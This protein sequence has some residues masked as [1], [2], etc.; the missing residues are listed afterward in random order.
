[1]GI[2][3][4]KNETLVD[5]FFDDLKVVH[6]KSPVIQTNDYYPFGLTFNSYQRENSLPQHYLYQGMEL[7]P[8]TETYLTEYR[9][10][11]PALGRWN[12]IDPKAN[13]FHSPYVG[14]GNNPLFYIDPLGDTIIVNNTGYITRNDESDNLV[15]TTN[16]DG[17]LVALGEI[18][19][20][21]N[22]DD[23]YS[24]LLE[25]NI[26][27]SEGILNPLAFKALVTDGGDWDLKADKNSIFGL[28]ND[29]ETMF[30]FNGEKMESQDIGNHHFGAVALA[31]PIISTLLGEEGILKQAGLNQIEQARNVKARMAEIQRSHPIF[32]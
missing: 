3:C 27:E 12:Q 31:N 19:G 4:N 15:F 5:V 8:E 32:I 21:I 29:G 11:D 2:L 10:Y 9:T 30:T 17:E 18:G 13:E 6:T 14:M 24:N 1:M 25:Q 7:Q 20:E 26:E 22:V 28:G 16:G 23:I